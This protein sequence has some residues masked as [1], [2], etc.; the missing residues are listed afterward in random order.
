MHTDSNVA[1]ALIPKDL[2]NAANGNLSQIRD[3]R[4]STIAL[5]MSGA[6]APVEDRQNVMSRSFSFGRENEASAYHSVQYD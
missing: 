5:L 2:Q 1:D 4:R 6:D 3:D